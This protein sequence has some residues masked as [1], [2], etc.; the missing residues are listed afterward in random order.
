MIWDLDGLEGTKITT[1]KEITTA[2][3][4]SI[5]TVFKELMVSHIIEYMSFMRIFPRL[6]DHEMNAKIESLIN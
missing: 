5:E 4:V 2:R 3:K 6:F 1:F